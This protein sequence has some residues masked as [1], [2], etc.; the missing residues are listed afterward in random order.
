MAKS[1]KATPSR[2]STKTKSTNS[3]NKNRTVTKSDV[4]AAVKKQLAPSI[5]LEEKTIER[6]SYGPSSPKPPKFEDFKPIGSLVPFRSFL[7]EGYVVLVNV[8][9]ITSVQNYTTHTDS[10]Q[11]GL[12][13][14]L[15]QLVRHSL[16]EVLEA[17]RK[18]LS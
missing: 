7:P 10:V 11:I 9:Y 5:P 1:K 4:T 12:A 16:T 14:G 6:N 18:N 2:T 13:S 3:T 17:I 15:T 8:N